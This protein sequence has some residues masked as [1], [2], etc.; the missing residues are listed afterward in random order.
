[1]QIRMLVSMSRSD[2]FHALQG[3]VIELD[4]D[5]AREFCASGLATTEIESQQPTQTQGVPMPEF[6]HGEIDLSDGVNEQEATLAG[7]TLAQRK[8]K[9]E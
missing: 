2:G 9:A 5:T 7:K 3:Q 1:M 4:D 6:A 8:R